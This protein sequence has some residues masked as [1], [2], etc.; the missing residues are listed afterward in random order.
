M[1]GHV[2]GFNKCVI[3][4]S[5]TVVL[6]H[7]RARKGELRQIRFIPTASEIEIL[8]EYNKW[9]KPCNGCGMGRNG[10]EVV[11]LNGQMCV[12]NRSHMFIGKEPEHNGNV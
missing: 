12:D 10:C 9:S 1:P 4:M 2:L 3:Q 7:V 11:D 6:G 5:C 8:P